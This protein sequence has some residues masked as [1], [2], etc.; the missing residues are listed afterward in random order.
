MIKL[1]N[2]LL[3]SETVKTPQEMVDYITQITPE[4][5]D[6]PEYFLSMILKAN[7]TFKLKDVKIEDILKSDPDVK[8]YVMSGEER[9]S[10]DNEETDYVPN[11]SDLDLPIVI[12]NGEV[13][14]GYSRTA[15]KYRN[16]DDTI[17]AWVS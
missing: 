13:M 3:E 12:M 4:E 16:G 8:D 11:P 10:D 5:K 7:K 2:I 6:L 9:Y 15:T 1:L 17:R 14:D